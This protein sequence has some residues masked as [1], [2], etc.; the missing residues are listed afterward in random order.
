MTSAE[1][2]GENPW[3]SLSDLDDALAD[4]HEALELL[5]KER[6]GSSISRVR[7]E[8]DKS[9]DAEG[10][11]KLLTACHG[12]RLLRDRVRPYFNLLRTDRWGYP[13]VYPQGGLW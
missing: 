5:L 13:L 1:L 12:D 11:D 10:A 4:S 7:N 9:C 6:S 3:L 2:N 8:L